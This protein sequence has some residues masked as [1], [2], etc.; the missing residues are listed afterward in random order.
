MIAADSGFLVALFHEKDSAHLDATIRLQEFQDSHTP[1]VT[2]S[3]VITE[4]FHL[5]KNR[6]KLHH[7]AIQTVM[8]QIQ[9]FKISVVQPT[10]EEAV[11]AAW[12]K[13]IGLPGKE[14]DY[15]DFHLYVTGLEMGCQSIVAT[16]SKDHYQLNGAVPSLVAKG[17][18]DLP[19]MLFPSYAGEKIIILERT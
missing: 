2:T 6:E 4:I 7:G 13:Y 16:D 3:P 18:L 11:F 9:T 5:L 19:N 17:S 14:V 8:T 15:T 1:V 10:S 12:T